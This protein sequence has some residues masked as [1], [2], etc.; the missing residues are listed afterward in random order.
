[1]RKS[2]ELDTILGIQFKGHSFVVYYLNLGLTV[3]ITLAH[4]D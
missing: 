4:L 3:Q 2:S 1:M